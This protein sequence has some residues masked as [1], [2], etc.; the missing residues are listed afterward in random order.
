MEAPWCWVLSVLTGSSLAL[1]PTSFCSPPTQPRTAPGMKPGLEI[2][3]EPR[4]RP[5]F[6]DTDRA[7]SLVPAS[8]ALAI[9]TYP[10]MM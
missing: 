1:L 4:P 10:G 2:Q 8:P 5:G 7:M 3:Q 6:G 9:V